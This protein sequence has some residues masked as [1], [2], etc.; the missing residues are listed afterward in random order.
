MHFVSPVCYQ[1]YG[2]S[3]LSVGLPASR[4]ILSNPSS[5]GHHYNFPKISVF[6]SCCKFLNIFLIA[7]KLHFSIL[8]R[9][10]S[11]PMIYSTCILLA[12]LHCCMPTLQTSS[13]TIPKTPPLSHLGIHGYNIP[14]I[15][16][17]PPSSPWICL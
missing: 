9:L 13:L 17:A 10:T 11:P 4:L 16:K 5:S 3:S 2:C 1:L 15:W 7:L 8:M 12:S 14:S 6:H